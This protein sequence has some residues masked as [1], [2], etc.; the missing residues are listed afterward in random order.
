[1]Y[2]EIFDA[3]SDEKP[4]RWVAISDVVLIYMDIFVHKMEMILRSDL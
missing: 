1:M 3:F 4:Q 2:I